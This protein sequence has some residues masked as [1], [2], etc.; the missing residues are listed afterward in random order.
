[1]TDKHSGMPLHWQI[2][3]ALLVA[4]VVGVILDP[5]SSLLGI[6]ILSALTFVG[7]LFLNA[8]KM[9]I[10]PL[11]MASII[12]GMMELQ[13]DTLGRLGFKTLHNYSTRVVNWI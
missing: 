3:I 6:P 9:L 11:I 10:V 13:A 5:S 4:V 2:L 7:T 1:M 12:S 8:L